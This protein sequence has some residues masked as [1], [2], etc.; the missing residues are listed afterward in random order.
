[1]KKI[2]KFFL[3]LIL[4]FGVKVDARLVDTLEGKD[5]PSSSSI[6]KPVNASTSSSITSKKC[7]DPKAALKISS[8]PYSS[9]I[10]FRY[11]TV[12][13][14]Y[15]TYIYKIKVNNQIYDGFCID[16]G[17]K[18]VTS[19]DCLTC[20]ALDESKGYGLLTRKM[21][22]LGYFDNYEND[23]HRIGIPYRFLAVLNGDGRLNVAGNEDLSAFIA[24]NQ[25]RGGMTDETIR[26]NPNLSAYEKTQLIWVYNNSGIAAYGGKKFMAGKTPSGNDIDELYDLA[27]DTYLE[28]GASTN[29]DNDSNGGLGGVSIELIS[30]NGL[31]ATLKATVPYTL[32]TIE[33]T[34]DGCEFVNEPEVG[35]GKSTTFTVNVLDPNCKFTIGVVTNG[36]G[37]YLCHEN[38]SKQQYII[39]APDGNLT[40]EYEFSLP[41]CEACV[42][43]GN[44]TETVGSV[45]SKITGEVN[46]CCD[47]GS[48]VVEEPEIDDL[49]SYDDCY[50]VSGYRVRSGAAA[51]R[52]TDAEGTYD[53]GK[54]DPD[55]C[56]L[57][58]TQ[59]A[60]IDIPGEISAVNGRYFVL[61]EQSVDVL[62]STITTTGA[63]AQGYKRC[64]L[65]I[66]YADW[67][68]EYM[69]AV[70]SEISNYN[71]YQEYKKRHELTTE[72][73]K[74]KETKS[75][76]Y[77]VTCIAPTVTASD[78]CPSSTP[79]E[80][81]ESCSET[82]T[83]D[84]KSHTFNS[85]N[86]YKYNYNNYQGDYWRRWYEVQI[87]ESLVKTYGLLKYYDQ[88][89]LEDDR[90]NHQIEY[91]TMTWQLF[92][93]LE[94]AVNWANQY[95]GKVYATASVSCCGGD[96]AT[97]TYSCTINHIDDEKY[98]NRDVEG[99][100]EPQ[101]LAQYQNAA[102]AYSA[103]TKNAKILENKLY[104][105]DNYFGQYEGAAA[106]NMFDFD[107]DST[108]YYTQ[109]YLDD[110]G[111]LAKS[112][113]GVDFEKVCKQDPTEVPDPGLFEN[114]IG[115][116]IQVR[117][118]EDHLTAQNTSGIFGGGKALMKDF[119]C[120][121]AIDEGI[122]T[123]SYSVNG[124]THKGTMGSY[125][126][127]VC[128]RDT[129]LGLLGKAVLQ[130]T[131]F[132][133][134]LD[135]DYQAGK[136]FTMDARYHAYCYW[137]EQ[138]NT[139]YT[140]APYGDVNQGN[141]NVTIRNYNIHNQ[142]Y[143]VYLTTLEGTFETHWDMS[144]IGEN[145]VFDEYI[146]QNGTT[147][148]G[149]TISDNGFSPFT[150]KLKVT[151]Q[152]VRTGGCDGVVD[153]QDH[154]YIDDTSSEGYMLYSFKVVDFKNIFPVCDNKGSSESCYN[155]IGYA[156]NWLQDEIGKQVLEEIE[157]GEA[158]DIDNL[159]YSFVLSGSDMKKIR[160]YN[161]IQIE[162]GGYTDFE[163][164]CKHACMGENG[165]T[166]VDG[167]VVQSENACTKCY[168]DFL[169]DLANGKINIAGNEESVS[170]WTN[171][172][173]TLSYI[174][175]HNNW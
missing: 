16:P 42:T 115:D 60:R 39:Y 99:S 165:Y 121:A 120:A 14:N 92:P 9:D 143:E 175:E 10:I 31:Q 47:G 84:T 159:T 79:G 171:S 125:G 55:Y 27:R 97:S 5:V 91:Q 7:I 32:S 98:E 87:K 113:T 11:G 13:E 52:N 74:T 26:N 158:F 25:V 23:P 123:S 140:L 18:S 151:H 44:R 156:Y 85:F 95:D 170:G 133:N 62:G 126:E 66:K 154:C 38:T 28:A 90:G 163:L 86:Y 53:N 50:L 2:F 149:Q 152:L 35:A 173:K 34:C 118:D 107:P 150:C 8:K 22:E 145:G 33:Y 82:K 41:T 164:S 80:S 1:M 146:S 136:Q 71:D 167:Q 36:G 139:K 160:E 73:I 108:F 94:E 67:L 111:S 17:S 51:Y 130:P 59:R 117:D 43:T 68:K 138:E 114:K 40:N 78:S 128:S 162:K 161:R 100:L 172:Q 141:T 45:D 83:G 19:S 54:I 21:I 101:L 69:E 65:R 174:R 4:I 48:T 132:M 12:E 105:C 110:L 137:E 61:K 15:L 6:S 77:V 124:D 147:C 3:I 122:K 63:V 93:R 142:H 75:H 64:R 168:S 88:V 89:E 29:I 131:A 157:S 103:A 81:G 76:Q 155:S 58:C 119:R 46:N 24:Y 56:E 129:A 169:G 102:D 106:G 30:D 148:A 96:T 127:A 134:F 104:V 70:D 72:V 49:F 20:D 112:T 57:Y 166:I 153:D 144:N 116:V 135:I 37:V 109:I